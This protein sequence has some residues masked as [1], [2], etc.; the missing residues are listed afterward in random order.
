MGDKWSFF[1]N[2]MPGLHLTLNP[3][4]PLPPEA[5]VNAKFLDHSLPLSSDELQALLRG[6]SDGIASVNNLLGKVMPGFGPDTR[7]KFA[8]QITD[9]LLDKSLDAQLSRDAPNTLDRLRLRDDVL[10]QLFQAPLP[11]GA[12]RAPAPSLLEQIPVG[13]SLTVYF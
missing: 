3:Q 11:A 1:N 6:R 8:T 5:R 2:G 13:V 9:K 4:K 7:L 10:Q 12:K